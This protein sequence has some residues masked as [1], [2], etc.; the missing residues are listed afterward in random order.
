MPISHE[1]PDGSIL[2]VPEDSVLEDWVKA[3]A[4][5]EAAAL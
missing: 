3:E 5:R 2:D 1:L 4:E